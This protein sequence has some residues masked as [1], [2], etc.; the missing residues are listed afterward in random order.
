M[1]MYI[2]CTIKYLE[3]LCMK[4]ADLQQNKGISV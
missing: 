2:M 4:F 3:D 1:P